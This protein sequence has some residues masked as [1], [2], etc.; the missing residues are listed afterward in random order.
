MSPNY[1]VWIYSQETYERLNILVKMIQYIR[2]VLYFL[3]KCTKETSTATQF[4][5]IVYL[6]TV[7]Y[8]LYPA[9][10]SNVDTAL[11]QR[12]IRFIAQLLAKPIEEVSREHF[13]EI[14]LKFW[15]HY[16][17]ISRKYWKSVSMVQCYKYICETFQNN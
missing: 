6:H 5:T 2:K 11:I 3:Y 15:Y 10:K 12:I 7:I 1:L 17:E 8:A 9:G 16:F 14:S 13:F 4:A